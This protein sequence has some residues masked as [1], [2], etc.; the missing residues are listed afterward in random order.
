MIQVPFQTTHSDV[1]LQKY[2]QSD[3]GFLE[4]TV[5]ETDFTAAYYAV[6]FDGQPDGNPFDSFTARWK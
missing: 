3:L 1:T 4:V 5:T 2:N 6:P